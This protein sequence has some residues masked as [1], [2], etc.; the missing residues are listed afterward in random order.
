[1]AEGYTKLFDISDSSLIE[2]EVVNRYIFMWMLGVCDFNGFFDGSPAS[3]ARRA[4]VPLKDM[5]CA[6]ELFQAPD[7]DSRSDIEEG[8]RII[9]QGGNQWWV[10]NK[11]EYRLKQTNSYKRFRDRLRKARQ[12]AGE[13][14]DEEEW[15]RDDALKNGPMSRD[16]HHEDEDEDEDENSID[17]VVSSKSSNT[18]VKRFKPPT[19]EEV[20]EYMKWPHMVKDSC[21]LQEARKFVGYYEG[22]GW[23]KANG[24]KMKVWRASVAY[25]VNNNPGIRKA[26]ERSNDIDRAKKI[27][28]KP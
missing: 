19:V 5:E 6:L 14:W 2:L 8:R 13:E 26:M 7:H 23:K 15:I 3:L 21:L 9:Y 25:W 28:V 18:P 4:N 20:A 11:V 17:S 1:M 10:V 12:R 16:S 24:Q 22:Q 27:G